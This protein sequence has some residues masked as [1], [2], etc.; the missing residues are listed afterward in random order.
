MESIWIGQS[1]V[2]P[3]RCACCLAPAERVGIERI[4]MGGGY[5]RW[6][7]L[8]ECKRC[9]AWRNWGIGLGLAT[10]LASFA[11]G[12]ALGVALF[13]LGSMRAIPLLPVIGLGMLVFLG[14]R[15]AFHPRGHVPSCS[16][17]ARSE[18][19]EFGGLTQDV[20]VFFANPEF[21]ALWRKVNPS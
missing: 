14:L 4:D 2:L 13:P 19:E 1:F 10:L 15:R 7:E 3:N 9:R 12:I 18:V 21:A 6:V 5:R 17:I 8:P 11:L 20:K 16:P